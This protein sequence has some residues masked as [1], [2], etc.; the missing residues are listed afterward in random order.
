MPTGTCI[1]SPTV[2]CLTHIDV[3]LHVSIEMPDC[4]TRKDSTHARCLNSSVDCL[5]KLMAS[6]NKNPLFE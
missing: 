4:E 5:K 6:K 1:C 2:I 3:Q